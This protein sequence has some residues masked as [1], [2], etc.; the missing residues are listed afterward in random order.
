VSGRT[1]QPTEPA[2]EAGLLERARFV[3]ALGDHLAAAAAGEGR[4]VLITAEAGGGKTALLRRFRAEHREDARV[5]WGACD[6]LFTPRALGPFLDV[7]EQAGGDLAAIVAGEARPHDVMT[8]LLAELRAEIPT[9]VVLEDLH[10]ADEATLDV[11]SLAGRRIGEA[12]GLV[13]GSLRDDE[14]DRAHP[15]R[16]LLGELATS[17]AVTRLA[18]P[19]LSLDAVTTLALPHAVDPEE[20]HGRTGGNPF[21]VTE[22][23]AAGG[24]RIPSNVRDAVLARA[25]RLGPDARRLLDVVAVVPPDA[26]VWLL[27]ALAEPEL[28]HLDECV[29]SGML[30][31]ERDAV[32][33]RHELA[34]VAVEESIAPDRRLAL[35][36]AA[37]RALR[38]PAGGTPDP[39]RLAHHAE[40]AG[41]AEAVLAF[42]P[43]AGER[44]ASVRAHREAAAQYDRALRFAESVP[45]ERRA[46]L[47]ERLSYARY[48]GEQ[49][50]EAA[51][52]R[53]EA[54]ACHRALGDAVRKGDSL[55]WLSRLA[56][57]LGRTAEAERG[58][59]EAVELLES[60]PPGRELAWAY[61]NMAQ[62][63]MIGDE[64][65][66]AV[67]WGTRAVELAEQVGEQG[68]L[69]H[70]LT[71][72]GSSQL[73]AG[74]PD[75]LANLERSL[76]IALAAG[77]DEHVVRALSNLV[78]TAVDRR[79]YALAE[80]YVQEGI[81]YLTNFGVTYWLS[82]IVAN[83]AQIELELGRWDEAARSAEL[84]LVRPRS[85][86]LTR[87][88]ALVVQGRVRARRGDPER[89]PP[90]DEARALAAPTAELQQTAVVAAAR[91]E[92]ALLEGNAAMVRQE[93]DEPYALAQLRAEPW[94]LGEL[95]LLRRRAGIEEPVPDG[96]AEPY[97]LE[98]AG[99]WRR[100]AELW[101][102]LGC[103]YE[104][105]LALAESGDE[106]AL[107]EALGALERLGARPA[108]TAV[109]RRLRELVA[110]GPRRSTASNPANL[111]ARE[112]EVLELVVA[113]LRNADIAERLVV[114]QRTVD[115][116]VSAILRKLGARSRAEAGALA[117]R[118][119]LTR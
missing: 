100:A 9:V 49:L 30:R 107:R 70:A 5:L 61:A 103:P 18:L 66:A 59:R 113:G 115:H 102:E 71:S 4:V 84:A 105:A 45:L 23:L 55:R 31:F 92:A 94:W 28:A 80:R 56:W 47:Y 2:A 95:A 54:L 110:R 108:A 20:L 79:L 68:A 72:V 1:R 22:I 88:T 50:E 38:A 17:R 85:L 116:H 69:A 16:I 99:Q 29:A 36:R 12:P 73:R 43:L 33:F 91:A 74:L 67:E 52:A 37:L 41:D 46:A 40:A 62:L 89:W 26:E 24:N 64:H 98:L 58:A 78:S 82:F 6:A 90:L 104:A 34:R 25:A 39:A 106:P 96:I 118:L 114:S 77:L 27:E 76:A 10:W 60:F 51:A 109:S 119:G 3:D 83:R 63:R 87:V 13:L 53:R 48:I 112:L 86:Q 101:T 15:L 11:L 93:T 35:H 57:C 111:T 42:A 14:L 7:A 32:A 44:A 117:I 97:A 65:L 21:F 75:G 81:D 19:P 8:A